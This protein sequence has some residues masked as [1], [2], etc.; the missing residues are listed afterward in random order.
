MEGVARGAARWSVLHGPSGLA[1]RKVPCGL[2][3]ALWSLCS[4]SQGSRVTQTGHFPLQGCVPRGSPTRAR[5]YRG[6]GAYQPHAPG[7][8]LTPGWCG[9]RSGPACGTRGTTALALQ[10]AMCMPC[11]RTNTWNTREPICCCREGGGR[12]GLCAWLSVA[13]PANKA[14]QVPGS[15]G[16]GLGRSRGACG[17]QGLIVTVMGRAGAVSSG[18]PV[19]NLKRSLQGCTGGPA[20]ASPHRDPQTPEQGCGR[21]LC[22]QGA[23]GP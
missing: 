6:P 5:G 9:P 12:S 23:P 11:T 19:F 8:V 16:M 18:Q 10:R 1:D 7:P 15:H 2:G 17:F 14:D 13:Q 21:G 22:R 20:A 4:E 3:P